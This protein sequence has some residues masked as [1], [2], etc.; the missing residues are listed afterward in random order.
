MASH[1][2]TLPLEHGGGVSTRVCHPSMQI[3]SSLRDSSH[4]AQG[5]LLRKKRHSLN[6]S[7]LKVLQK[8]SVDNHAISSLTLTLLS[9][10]PRPPPG[11]PSPPCWLLPGHSWTP[12][13]HTAR[14]PTSHSGHLPEGWAHAFT[15]AGRGGRSAGARALSDPVLLGVSSSAGCLLLQQLFIEKTC[16]RQERG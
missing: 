6:Q 10:S 5:L 12:F 13:L 2:G 16:Q 14:P 4:E 9:P 7:L 3:P 15:G 1:S 11:P 8:S